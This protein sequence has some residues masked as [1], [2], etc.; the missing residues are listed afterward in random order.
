MARD[1]GFAPAAR[2]RMAAPASDPGEER[3]VFG[4]NWPW[5]V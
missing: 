1:V 5:D 3:A 4:G 2:Q